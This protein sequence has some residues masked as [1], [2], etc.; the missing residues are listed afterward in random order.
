MADT[1]HLPELGQGVQTALLCRMGDIDHAGLDHV[2]VVLI[3]PVGPQIFPDLRSP[4]LASVVGRQGQDLVPG[5]LDGSRLVM[6]DV[7]GDG[8]DDAL[9]VTEDGTG[10]EGIDLGASYQQMDLGLGTAA[11]RADFLHGGG[12]IG[13]ISITEGLFHIGADQCLH[14]F[15]AGS[16]HVVVFKIEHV[17]SCIVLE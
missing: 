4:Q 13:V 5:G 15:R 12:S 9:A 8:R 14:H 11:G 10:G 6:V 17:A 16:P 2:G 7:A 3:G 1:G